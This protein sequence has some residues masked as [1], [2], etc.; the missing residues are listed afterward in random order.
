MRDLNGITR[1]IGIIATCTAIACGYLVAGVIAL[2]FI[3]AA[4]KCE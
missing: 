1:I 2:V 4:T 3:L